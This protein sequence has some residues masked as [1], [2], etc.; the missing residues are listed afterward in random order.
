LRGKDE[1]LGD[2]PGRVDHRDNDRDREQR[3]KGESH[4]NRILS[5]GKAQVDLGLADLG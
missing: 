1:L 5:I 2:G 4:G 3:S